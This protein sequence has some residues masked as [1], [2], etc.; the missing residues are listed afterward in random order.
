[1]TEPHASLDLF[2]V[3]WRLGATIFF[4]LLNGF[5]VAA[6][7]ALVKVRVSRLEEHARRGGGSAR[8][9]RHI[10]AHLDRYLSACQLGITLASLILGALGEPAV[11]RLLLALAEAVGIELGPANRFV[12]VVSITLAFA[13]ITTLHMTLGEQAPKMW[14]LRRAEGT[15]LRTAYPLLVFTR[16]FGPFI[17]AVNGI[18]NALLRLA[19]LEP[20]VGHEGSHSAE[21]I[22]SILSLSARAGHISEREYELTENVFRM[23]DLE[24]RHIVVPRVDVEFL[25]LERPL[26]EALQALRESGHSRFPLCERGLD[27]IVG[28]VHGKDVL[29]R[30]LCGEE[31]ELRSLAR[32]PTFVPDTM[33]VSN[34]LIELQSQRAHCAAVLDEHGSV[35]G[36]AFREDALEE[37]VG[38]LGDEFDEHS[39]DV[40]QTGDG[41]FEVR[42]GLALPDL[43]DRLEIELDEDEGE[44]TVGGLVTARL[45]RLARKGDRVELP[46]FVVVVTE[47]GRRRIQRLRF[48]PPPAPG[49]E[50]DETETPGAA[51]D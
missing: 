45:G 15:A 4:V 3:A 6:E 37:I 32:P 17:A 5:F 35:M 31:P 9:A 44:E 36:L 22:R 39:P 30:V 28:F 10:V 41:I 47:V 24:V 20:E 29:D 34:F 49:P 12:P 11:S 7:F 13:V 46:P 1:M 25:S 19:G 26:E 2:G 33:S 8:A 27:T 16:V 51:S 42:G 14:A 38:P 43:C 23:M 48:E 50:L 21:E 40:R 18:S